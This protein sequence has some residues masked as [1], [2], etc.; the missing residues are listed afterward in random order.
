MAEA[1]GWIGWIDKGARG[2]AYGLLILGAIVCIAPLMS[3]LALAF[4]VGLALVLAGGL[5]AFFGLSARDAG[6]GNFPLA[7][8]AITAVTGL[9]LVFQPSAGLKVVQSIL[10]V[11]LLVRSCS[12][13][14]M[15]LQ[16]GP[17]EGRWEALGG[18]LVSI[19][20]GWV[21]WSGWPISGARVVGV[22]VGATLISTGLVLLRVHRTI[23]ASREKLRGARAALGEI[24]SARDDTG[25]A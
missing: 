22:A 7:I 8:G 4:L 9:V 17:D 12:E 20:T 1:T 14:A 19:V 13:I 18:G 21:L 6:K 3:G 16:L 10:V 23:E 11:Y 24:R 15:A 2:A 25:E 5:I